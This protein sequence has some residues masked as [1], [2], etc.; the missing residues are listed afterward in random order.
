MPR[1]DDHASADKPRVGLTGAT[2][3][4]GRVLMRTLADDFDLVGMSRRIDGTDLTDPDGLAERFAGLDA[5]VHLAWQYAEHAPSGAGYF[6]NLAMNRNVLEAAD[7][8]GVRV[9]VMASSVHADYFYDHN[10]QRDGLLT[11]QRTPRGNGPYGCAKVI[12]EE[13]GREFAAMQR[14]AGPLRVVCI[15]YGAVTPDGQP[16]GSDAWERRVWLS[17]RDLT[18]L[19]RRTLTVDAPEPFSL[20]YAVSDNAGRVHDVSNPFGW[21]PRDSASALPGGDG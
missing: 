11:V 15:R 14:D 18:D 20:L 16:H 1:S 12:V 9:A 4:I 6:D 2:G 19:I 21:V 10:P 8:A 7:A 5:V 13:M 17:H 3:S